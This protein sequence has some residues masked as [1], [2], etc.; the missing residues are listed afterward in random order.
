VANEMANKVLFCRKQGQKL[1][2]SEQEEKLVTMLLNA[3]T[4][5]SSGSISPLTSNSFKLYKYQILCN[6]IELKPGRY[7]EPYIELFN[8]YLKK[9]TLGTDV[10]SSQ[11]YS[12][13][14]V[15]KQ[16]CSAASKGS[17]IAKEITSTQEFKTFANSF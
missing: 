1:L 10:P 4:L 8:F 15:R 2:S 9:K 11:P 14:K 12:R 6:A 7:L 17:F 5:V 13:Q 16:L 3:S